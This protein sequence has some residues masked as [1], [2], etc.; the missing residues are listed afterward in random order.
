MIFCD[1]C[2]KLGKSCPILK[3]S[4]ESIGGHDSI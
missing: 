1:L 4:T 2:E 3:E